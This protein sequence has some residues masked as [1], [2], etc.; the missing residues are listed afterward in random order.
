MPRVTPPDRRARVLEAARETF[1]ERGFAGAR[2]EDVAARV[3]ISRSALYAQFDGKEALFRALVTGLV[4]EVTPQVLPA[5]LEGVSGPDAVRAFIHAAMH[6]LTRPD[7]S[8]LPRIVVGE[9]AAFPDLARHYHDASLQ[10]VLM[11]IEQLVRHGVARGEFVCADP[12]LAARSIAGGVMIT[13]LWRSVFE[14][15]GVAPIDVA[16]MAAH[17]ADLILD[18]LTVRKENAA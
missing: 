17:H 8:F 9:G 18:G 1:A 10:R 14:P 6:R 12:A 15:V 7:F 11:R 2:M 4:E 3:G 13:V 5:S 16:A